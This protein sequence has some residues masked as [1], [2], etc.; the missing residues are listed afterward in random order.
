M[1]TSTNNAKVVEMK[2]VAGNKGLYVEIKTNDNF[3]MEAEDV[4]MTLKAIAKSNIYLVGTPD[5]RKNDTDYDFTMAYGTYTV[6]DF[7]PVDASTPVVSFDPS[8]KDVEMY[9]GD[10]GEVVFAVNADNQKDLFL[11]YDDDAVEAIEDKYPEAELTFHNFDGNNKTF[12]RTGTLTIPAEAVEKENGKMGAP[13]LYTR[14]GNKMVALKAD[15]DEENEVFTVKTNKLENYVV[16][17]V[18]LKATTDTDSSS[19]ETVDENGNVV[20]P[21]TGANDFVGLAVAL[22]VVS[23]AGIAVAKKH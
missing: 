10:E 21:D 3:I 23:V 6:T 9:F 13:Y 11:R 5:D 15:W 7:D 20:N 12:R 14:D 4:S 18:E 1:I 17:N 16:S 2:D 22:A 8:D 19:S